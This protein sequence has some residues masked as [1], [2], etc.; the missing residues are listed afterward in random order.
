METIAFTGFSAHKVYEFREVFDCYT[1]LTMSSNGNRSVNSFDALFRIAKHENRTLAT[2][3]LDRR[4]RQR[5]SFHQTRARKDFIDLLGTVPRLQPN[6]N[7]IINLC[8]HLADL[9]N[10]KILFD[11]LTQINH[12]GGNNDRSEFRRGG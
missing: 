10:D 11:F 12:F 8:L 1:G 3:C 2:A 5:L 6:S 4:N 7:E 9:L